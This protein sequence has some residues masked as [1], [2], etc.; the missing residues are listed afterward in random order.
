VTIDPT[1]PRS[2]ALMA[3][4]YASEG[5]RFRLYLDPDLAASGLLRPDSP[6]ASLNTAAPVTLAE[7]VAGLPEAL[8]RFEADTVERRKR[9]D[10]GQHSER[11]KAPREF[12]PFPFSEAVTVGEDALLSDLYAVALDYAAEDV[13]PAVLLDLFGI[14][15]EP[16]KVAGCPNPRDGRP[17]SEVVPGRVRLGVFEPR[18]NAR[19]WNTPAPWPGFG[20]CSNACRTSFG[21]ER[22]KAHARL[23]EYAASVASD[24]AAEAERFE[25]LAGTYRAEVEYLRAA[26]EDDTA[27][28]VT[29]P[30]EATA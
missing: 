14:D 10:K 16:F 2:A 1:S 23:T 19:E 20:F 11:R 15:L 22:R 29:T 28:T 26:L 3:K 5:E 24:L 6:L 7:A 12:L 4:F 30:E 13:T 17:C 18:H 27:V 8:Q 21:N 25:A 9:A